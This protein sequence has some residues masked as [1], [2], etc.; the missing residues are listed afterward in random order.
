MKYDMAEK[1]NQDR[2]KY[3]ALKEQYINDFIDSIIA[4]E[5][6]IRNTE[7]SIVQSVSY[8][9]LDVYKRQMLNLSIQTLSEK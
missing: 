5:K 9:H 4:E 7:I 2:K 8:T 6:R 3:Q 1:A